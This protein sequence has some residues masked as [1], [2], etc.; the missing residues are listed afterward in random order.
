M[1][2]LQ[3]RYINYCIGIGIYV[4]IT[5]MLFLFAGITFDKIK[6]FFLFECFF[7]PGSVVFVNYIFDRNCSYDS[8]KI[9]GG[10]RVLL[11]V[12]LSVIVIIIASII[13]NEIG[14]HI[15]F[16]D[17]DTV[18]LGAG[19]QLDEYWSNV[20]T[21]TVI[22]LVLC[23]PAF[24]RE[25]IIDKKNQQLSGLN[26]E[27]DTLKLELYSSNVKPH[28]IFNT[29]N[30]IVTLIHEEPN[31]AEKMTL[32]LSD[33]LRSSLY[34]SNANSHTVKDEFSVMTGYLNIE[35]IK[36]ND[37]F[38]YE[39][40]LD[41]KL[42]NFNVPKFFLLPIVENAIKH[43]RSQKDIQIIISAKSNVQ[44]VIFE[45]ADTGKNFPEELNY[46]AGIKGTISLLKSYFGDN[47]KLETENETKKLLRIEINK[48]V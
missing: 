15:G 42:Q 8:T 47:F 14:E 7:I 24:V 11:K 29:L 32:L 21:N 22:L 20:F 10:L 6:I 17:D 26:T 19:V 1:E 34:S 31:K 45:V 27:L 36:F 2:Q 9:R 13:N 41:E 23:I 3:K 33:F 30:G 38:S 43:N 44:K 18:S 28:F 46:S 5:L 37:N 25:N 35:Q 4:T 39:F 12:L 16:F 40:K 48:N